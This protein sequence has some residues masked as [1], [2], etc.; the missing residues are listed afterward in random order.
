MQAMPRARCRRRGGGAMSTLK[1]IAAMTLLA[2]CGA[3][4][5]ALAGE[6]LFREQQPDAAQPRSICLLFDV[7]GSMGN[8]VPAADGPLPRTQLQALQEAAG[9]FVRRQDLHADAL[10]LVTFSYSAHVL[11]RMGHDA[12][13]LLRRIG[14]LEAH[15]GTDLARGL[16]AAREVLVGAPGV[17]WILLFTDGKPEV[18]GAGYDAVQASLRA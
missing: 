10:G 14:G 5:G 13:D 7:S 15:G 18:A 1:K 9:S 6:L 17:H 4:L 16:D 11:A 8:R 3:T 12:A 2:A